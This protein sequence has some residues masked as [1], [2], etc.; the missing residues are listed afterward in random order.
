[1]VKYETN[2]E[3]NMSE[4]ELDDESFNILINLKCKNDCQYSITCL[5]CEL[6]THASDYAHSPEESSTEQAR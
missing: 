1:M 6:I 5:I 3:I 2:R 4:I